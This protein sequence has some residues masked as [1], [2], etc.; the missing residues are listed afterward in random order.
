MIYT[1]L[2]PGLLPELVRFFISCGLQRLM[3]LNSDTQGLGGGRLTTY[4]NIV[5]ISIVS[6]TFVPLGVLT[7]GM[8]N[9]LPLFSRHLQ[10]HAWSGGARR[11]IWSVERSSSMPSPCDM[12]T[13]VAER[14]GD[15]ASLGT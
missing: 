1:G 7:L 9:A 15:A 14:R 13:L 3:W 10:Y 12:M 11:P 2:K 6:R 4:L 5:E 8:I